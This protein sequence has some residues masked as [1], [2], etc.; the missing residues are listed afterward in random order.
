MSQQIFDKPTRRQLLS[1]YLV[2]G[3]AEF[4]NY[5]ICLGMVYHL[6]SRF[7][8][9][10]FAIGIASSVNTASYLLFC[11]FFES[12][13][14]KIKPAVCIMVSLLGMG[15]CA[16]VLGITSS[17]TLFIV[18][19]FL[20]GAFR[21]ML[22]P[23]ITGLINRGK[24]GIALSK[25][26]GGFNLSWNLFAGLSPLFSGLIL[27]ASTSIV[28]VVSAGLIYIAMAFLFSSPLTRS[29]E[30]DRTQIAAEG[31][32]DHSTVL[33]F[34]AWAGLV[35]VYIE[36]NST[37]TVFPLF[38]QD[39][40]GFSELQTGI[41][42]SIKGTVASVLFILIGRMSWWKFKKW[43]LFSSQALLVAACLLGQQ[44]AD[45]A[46]ALVYCLVLGV[47]FAFIYSQALF[48]AMSGAVNKS[49]RM[50]FHE[51]ILTLG[52]VIGSTG[53]GY[54]YRQSGWAYLM[55]DIMLLS[56]AVLAIELMLAYYM[57]RNNVADY[58]SH[59]NDK[60]SAGSSRLTSDLQK[61]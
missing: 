56:I 9:D 14:E 26:Q 20:Y 33:R 37:L 60:D 27:Q 55:Q 49:K 28:F 4:A 41:L 52:C 50:M 18:L 36:S 54:V 35:L 30:S 23:Q 11:L 44:I 34:F 40:L 42:L 57:H 29:A 45:F 8:L 17:V 10:S 7:G 61:H 25:A 59:F 16:L 32:K 53:G 13:Y 5:M 1:L 19:L 58:V 43:V 39:S 2:C 46:S 21:S 15:S 22:W 47:C 3:I 24:E 6:S 51:V 38:G 12:Q 48:Y 31:M